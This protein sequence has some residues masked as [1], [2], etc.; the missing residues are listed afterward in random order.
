MRA[1]LLILT[2]ILTLISSRSFA[3]ESFNCFDT[4]NGEHK[5]ACIGVAGCKEM[6]QSGNCKSELVCDQDQLGAIICSCNAGR[7]SR[8]TSLSVFAE[9]NLGVSKKRIGVTDFVRRS[10]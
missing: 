4:P 6:Q 5:C 10:R 2:V 9:P 7:T 8:P 3:L 1:T